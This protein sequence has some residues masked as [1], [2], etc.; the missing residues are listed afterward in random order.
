MTLPFHFPFK[1][2]TLASMAAKHWTACFR[3]VRKQPMG[4]RSDRAA[5]GNLAL[6]TCHAT[7]FTGGRADPKLHATRCRRDGLFRLPGRT[8]IQDLLNARSEILY[9]FDTGAE[10]WLN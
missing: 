3:S 1:P 10:S 2:W 4:R 6:F 9:T 5:R 7:T 8:V